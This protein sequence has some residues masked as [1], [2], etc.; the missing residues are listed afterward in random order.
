MSQTEVQGHEKKTYDDISYEV[1]ISHIGQNR[2]K[3]IYLINEEK[4]TI[5]AAAREI[6]IKLCTAKYIL[7]LY[8]KYGKIY[9][10]KGDLNPSFNSPRS[11]PIEPNIMYVP[12]PVYIFCYYPA[13]Q[14]PINL[15][16][17]QQL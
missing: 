13:G 11:E 12:Y 9:K 15:A 10:K 6:G 3:L 14:M 4:W 5:K 7:Y 1:S 16:H 17:S 8:R 2:K